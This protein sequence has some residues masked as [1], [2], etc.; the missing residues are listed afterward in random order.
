[1]STDTPTTRRTDIR[2][3]RQ[4]TTDRRTEREERESEAP[5]CPDVGSSWVSSRRRIRRE[6]ALVRE[7]LDRIERHMD[8]E[9][10]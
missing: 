10:Q 6:L 5:L 4:T 3:P 7:Q 8:M 2:T 1:M 9:A